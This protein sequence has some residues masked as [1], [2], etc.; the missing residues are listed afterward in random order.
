MKNVFC[1]IIMTCKL[2]LQQP[3]KCQ[4]N[5]TRSVYAERD[6]GWHS[7]EHTQAKHCSLCSLQGFH[8]TEL[9]GQCL[10][11]VRPCLV[12]VVLRTAIYMWGKRN[13]PNLQAVF[14]S[15]FLFTKRQRDKLRQVF[16][17]SA[18]Q[19]QGSTQ[20]QPCLSLLCVCLKW[21]L[22]FRTKEAIHRVGY[23]ELLCYNSSTWYTIFIKN[24][25]FYLIASPTY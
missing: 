14:R 3:E 21:C 25:T 17:E 9:W 22:I 12:L 5:E 19:T 11:A 2:L 7:E 16:R 1:N 23:R 13:R 6:W 24:S 15:R 4:M 20:E 18:C 10:T 8:T